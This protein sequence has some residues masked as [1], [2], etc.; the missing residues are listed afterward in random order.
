M[1]EQPSQPGDFAA[2]AQPYLD[3]GAFAGAILLAANRDRVLSVEAV[4][5]ADVEQRKPMRPDSVYWIASQTKPI[6]G[7]A[8]MMLIEEGKISLDDPVSKF[9]PE[10]KTMWVAV[11]K[12]EQRV[13]LRPASRPITVRDILCHISGLPFSSAV[14]SPSFDGL[15]LAIACKS[16]SMMQLQSEPGVKYSYSNAG[17]NAA[18]RI[19]EVVTGMSYEQFL[20]R[21]LLGPLG[22]D[23]TS[24]WPNESMLLRL[25]TSYAI[26][27]D[28]RKLT[29]IPIGQLHYLLSDRTRHPMPAGGLFSTVADCARFCQMILRGGEWGG[30]RY[31]SEASVATLVA[32][33][34]PTSVNEDYGLGFAR[35][36]GGYGHG[37]A[38]NT[39]M[40]IDPNLDL[41]NVFAIQ[42]SGNGDEIKK[43]HDAG[44]ASVRARFGRSPAKG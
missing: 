11:E 12:D 38:F 44:M 16:Y 6:T 28:T 9:L 35:G 33:H 29:P 13:V 21:R 14:E 31:L 1:S 18:G 32:R 23:D 43:C 2:I 3:K 34:T 17:I 20:D 15:P 24:F 42:H 4:G 30:R 40:W 41:I 37:G 25:A 26:P 10:F 19:M 8:V 27:E 7:T 22:M 5:F 36:D 39:V